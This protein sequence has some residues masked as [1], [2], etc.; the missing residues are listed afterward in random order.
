MSYLFLNTFNVKNTFF[1]FFSKKYILKLNNKKI[2]SLVS[3]DKNWFLN[4]FY[5]II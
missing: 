3:S 1:F 5:I 4:C 2:V